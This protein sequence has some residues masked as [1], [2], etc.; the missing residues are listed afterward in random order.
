[1]ISAV[2][3]ETQNS[4]GTAYIRMGRD[5]QRKFLEE[6]ISKLIKEYERGI[7]ILAINNYVNSTKYLKQLFSGTGQQSKQSSILV[8]REIQ[9]LNPYSLQLLL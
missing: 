2:K 1:M 4:M 8:R 5:G 7:S 3:R 6:V 9:K